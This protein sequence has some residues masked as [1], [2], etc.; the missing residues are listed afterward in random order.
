MNSTLDRE[1]LMRLAGKLQGVPYNW[2]GSNPL[3]GGLG[4][5]CSGFVI[6]I[7]QVFGVLEAGDWGAHNLSSMFERTAEMK[8]GNLVFYGMD[9]QHITH[10]MMAASPDMVIGASGGGKSTT[11]IEEAKRINAMVKYK[12]VNY[13][14]DL[15]FIV[16]IEKRKAV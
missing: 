1:S 8:P 14:R 15:R 5:D 13:R 4:L 6:W 2:G 16:D 12:A 11:T 9:D 10:V 3:I 7:L